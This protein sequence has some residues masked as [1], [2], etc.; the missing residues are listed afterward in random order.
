MKKHILVVGAR[1]DTKPV[2]NTT[3]QNDHHLHIFQPA[4]RSNRP[5][6]VRPKSHVNV[7]ALVSSFQHLFDNSTIVCTHHYVVLIH[8]SSISSNTRLQFI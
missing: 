1:K 2:K 3:S 4:D 5:S 6:V 7:F 8:R